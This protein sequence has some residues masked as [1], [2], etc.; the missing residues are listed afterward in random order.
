MKNKWSDD[1]T[2]L[3]IEKQGSCRYWTCVL[4]VQDLHRNWKEILIDELTD[5]AAA[6]SP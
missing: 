4:F 1:F 3:G 5:P 6:Y 2:G